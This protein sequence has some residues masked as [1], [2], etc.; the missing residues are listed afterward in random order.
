MQILRD[1]Q[2]KLGA[3]VR[4]ILWRG[5]KLKLLIRP[6]AQK[7]TAEVL[8]IDDTNYPHIRVSLNSRNMIDLNPNEIIV[9]DYGEN[10][11]IKQVLI[12][13]QLLLPT[14]RWVVVDNQLCEV[15]QIK[16]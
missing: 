8:L 12:N 15:C 1:Q 13:A 7:G 5:E 14:G 11:G 3:N 9:K 16:F 2:R 6:F 4:R 10:E